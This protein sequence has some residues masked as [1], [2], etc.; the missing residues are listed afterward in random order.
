[1]SDT[2]FTAPPTP[3]PP[4]PEPQRERWQPLRLGLVELFQYDSEEF[5]FRDGHLLLR[6]NNGTG[7]SKVLSLTLPFLFDANLR[8]SRIE[9]DGDGGK[10]MAWNLLMGTYPRRIGYAWIE[11]GR[12]AADGTVR[13]LTLGAGLSAVTGRTQVESWYFI[14]EGDSGG[15]DPRIG[16]DLWL[17]NDQRV[18]L[19]RDRLRE[20]LEGK[21]LG[22]VFENAHGY[23]RAV[24][25]RLFQL[26]PKRYDAL[27][28]TLIQLRQPQLSKKP[29]EAGLSNALTE[30]LPPMP[31]ELLTDVAEALNQL[32]EDRLQLERTRQLERAVKHF[33]Q[34]YRIYAGTSTRRQARDLRQAQTGYDN[35]S[36]ARN[37]AHRK[38]V[39]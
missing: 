29:D 16:Q 32:E 2:S 21:G 34:R 15:G 33:E 20:T 3:R 6:G 25:E 9:P 10:K 7:K 11:F 30:A 38:S 31:N 23:R 22:K 35:A 37:I 39:V 27:M 17:T 24:D 1:M 5:W 4:L 28:D 12:R 8:P 14:V 18:V 19:T 13:Y 26:G 36:E